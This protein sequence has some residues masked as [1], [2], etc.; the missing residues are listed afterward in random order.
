MSNKIK[1]IRVFLVACANCVTPQELNCD[2]I[3]R[4]LDKNKFDV[5]TLLYIFNVN[6]AFVEDKGV[7]YLR[8]LRPVRFFLPILIFCGI[9]RSDV[10]YSP[11][12][13][14]PTWTKLCIKLLRKKSFETVE[15]LLDETALYK[16][17]DVPAYIAGYRWYE[18]N[19]FAIST[20]V[21]TAVKSFHGLNCADE[22]LY[23]GTEMSEFYHIKKEN[24]VLRN[25]V[26]IGRETIRKRID[27]FL[28]MSKEFPGLQFHIAGGNKVT[29]GG[30]VEE[31][32]SKNNSKNVI[33]HGEVGRK[34]LVNLLKDM[35]VLFF[36]SRSEGFGKVTFEC[37]A[38]GV[39]PIVYGDYGA[40]DWIKTGMNGYVVD[41]YDE[42][43]S[44]IKTMVNDS[45]LFNRISRSSSE[46]GLSWDWKNIINIWEKVITR[47]ASNQ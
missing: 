18:P 13:I 26:F 21:K 9:L 29:G 17:K 2:A 44:A 1:K 37:A 32:I 38:S 47:I 3:S 43:V 39:V 22:I 15:G 6:N 31:W 11:V 36:P 24:S 25:V 4:H 46:L 7:K 33:Y 10:V 14:M 40:G 41:T 30:T 45:S 20:A 23:L 27:E 42:A 16:V 8:L 5:Y 28:E 19:L 34:E 35:D 12:G